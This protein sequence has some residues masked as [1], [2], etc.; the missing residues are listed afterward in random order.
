MA[1]DWAAYAVAAACLAAA[2]ALV[3]AAV[4][5]GRLLGRWDAKL[6]RLERETEETLRE[7]RRLGR[8]AAD[9]AER[10][11]RGLEGFER[12]AEGGRALGEAAETAAKV[13]AA[14]VARW[15][16]RL[17]DSS[18]PE[19]ERAPRQA[20]GPDWAEVGLSLWQAWRRRFAGP[21]E[22]AG[23]RTDGEA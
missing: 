5:V 15:G 16:E 7:W 20:A 18:A 11:R 3:F 13:A 23:G 21:P 14:A 4:A 8:E 9:A 19:R 12:L 17:S 1:W 10:C 2:A 6:A 22:D